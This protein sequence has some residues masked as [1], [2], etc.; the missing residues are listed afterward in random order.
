EVAR[1]A[2][3]QSARHLEVAEGQPAL[4]RRLVRLPAG[5]V[6]THRRNFPRRL[7]DQRIA[8]RRRRRARAVH[9]AREA[10]LRVAFPE[11]VAGELR[12][13]P[14]AR[15]AQ[16]QRFFGVL[17]LQE[18]AEEAANG[19]SGVEERRAALALRGPG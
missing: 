4:E 15:L 18:L 1:A 19:G 11:E 12:Q 8:D 16:A 14:E 9:Q 6:G 13:A 7:A 5:M 17:P 3:G 10:V 2:V